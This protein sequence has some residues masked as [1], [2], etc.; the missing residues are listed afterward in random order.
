MVLQRDPETGLISQASVDSNSAHID[1]SVFGESR[2][3]R[4]E[5]IKENNK[6]DSLLA[7]V[8]LSNNPVRNLETSLEDELLYQKHDTNSDK[9]HGCPNAKER[10]GMWIQMESFAVKEADPYAPFLNRLAYFCRKAEIRPC[11]DIQCLKNKEIIDKCVPRCEWPKFREWA[12]A[13]SSCHA[14]FLPQQR[15]SRAYFHLF[16]AIEAC[17]WLL[18]EYRYEGKPISG[19]L[20]EDWGKTATIDVFGVCEIIYWMLTIVDRGSHIAYGG[21]WG[22]NFLSK[23]ITGPAIAKAIER[24]RN[25]EICPN[26]LW[27]LTGVAER[28]EVDLPGLIETASKYPQLRQDGHDECTVGFCTFTT[29]DSTKMEQLH[30]CDNQLECK[31]L[32]QLWFDPVLLNESIKENERIAWSIKEPFEVLQASKYVAISH[33]WSDGTGIGLQEVGK[34][35]RCLFEYFSKI[36]RE[37]GFDGIWWDTISIP[38]D[39]EARRKAV[40]GMHNNYSSAAA[41]LLHDEYLINYKW[42]DDGSPCLAL[43]FSPWFTRG[44]TALE[45]IMSK[46]VL[47][48]YKGSDGR[49]VV[50]DLDNEVLAKD[51]SQCTRAH[52]IASSIIRRLRNR[53]IQNISDLMAILKPR[54]TSWE[55][56]LMVIA[57]LLAGVNDL[58]FSIR[59]D[60]ITKQVIS[61]IYKL[62]PASILHGKA[63][64]AES[65][66]WS[67]CPPSLYDMPVETVGDISE[68]DDIGDKTCLVDINGILVGS[69]H[70]RA[71][72]G[73]EVARIRVVSN[74]SD[75]TVTMKTE[76]ALRRWEYC[77]LLREDNHGGPGL[78]F[79]VMPVGRSRDFIN[80]KFIGT[81]RDI[82]PRPPGGYDPRFTFGSFKI[83]Q[84]QGKEELASKFC[85]KHRKS[86]PSRRPGENFDWLHGKLWMG[87]SLMGQLLVMFPEASTGTTGAF[88]LQVTQKN[89]PTKIP[90]PTERMVLHCD[91]DVKLSS[92]P[93]FTVKAH[94]KHGPD[95]R[96]RE[97]LARVGPEQS[98]QSWPPRTIPATDRIYYPKNE[99]IKSKQTQG[100]STAL[101][102]LTKEKP[103]VTFAAIDPSLFTPDTTRVYNGVWVG[104]LPSI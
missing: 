11:G 95:R 55:R 91:P 52:W 84:D 34:V 48:I 58:D 26:R 23:N 45:L 29:L 36:I 66:G 88:S 18:G 47:V 62:N 16:S 32:G 54:T 33:V 72:E 7:M 90:P 28:K 73:G 89:V 12:V 31:K 69:W 51:A 25:L 104:K 38:T 21:R 9:V 80:C 75:L 67:W 97:I 86:S 102:R 22:P 37:G 82:S 96:S 64:I 61:R 3:A 43:V 42:A 2:R 46:T 85:E 71:L 70:F 49:P 93:I 15:V 44:W 19:R 101:F 76:D 39:R 94:Q 56:D 14:S 98:G 50:K 60:K 53:D 99:N 4:S 57:A 63:T 100:F 103:P 5:L 30:K 59:R 40:N 20:I 65:G 83:G 17:Q 27:N 8:S 78:G 92:E 74:S 13:L 24:A 81:V 10:P 1:E 77:L 41:T 87:D 68:G 6:L 79:L 35:N